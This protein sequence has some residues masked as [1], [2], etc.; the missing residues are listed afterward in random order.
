MVQFTG[1]RV[2]GRYTDLASRIAVLYPL[3][4]I[5]KDIRTNTFHAVNMCT[6]RLVRMWRARVLQLQEM[7][8][9]HVSKQV[10]LDVCINCFPSLMV[11][12]PS[13]RLCKQAAVCPFCYARQV[14]EL[15]RTATRVYKGIPASA[16]T[17]YWMIGYKQVAMFPVPGKKAQ[18]LPQMFSLELR[19]RS[20]FCTSM[21]S[22]GGYVGSEFEPVRFD[23]WKV[24]R[25][26]VLLVPEGSDFSKLPGVNRIKLVKA[27]R[28]DRVAKVVG[29][30]MRYP[31]R[32]LR[33]GL[34]HRVVQLLH[35]KKGHRLYASFGVFRGK[36]K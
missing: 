21:Q 36:K 23:K 12:S 13:T 22:F 1:I 29:W 2:P 4:G 24:T 34:P 28:G 15:T 32:L 7:N 10:N 14:Q 19:L 3:T 8:W 25:R 9:F 11:M 27:Y 26:G 33:T 5:P 17:D 20:S 30:T 6:L 18:T 31:V 35:V 16:R